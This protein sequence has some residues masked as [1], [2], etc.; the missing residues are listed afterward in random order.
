MKRTI[1]VMLICILSFCVISCAKKKNQTV[2]LQVFKV[3]DVQSIKQLNQVVY[4][5]QNIKNAS[6]YH[7]EAIFSFAQQIVSDLFT[8]NSNQVFSPLS[9]YIA[10]SMLTEGISDEGLGKKMENFL[11]LSVDQLRLFSKATFE[12]NYYS[13]DKGRTYLSNSMWIKHHF[14]INSEYID[15]LQKY[16]FVEAYR[17]D[18]TSVEAK[19]EIVRWINHYTEN[20]LDLNLD[21]YPI[22]D[23]LALLLLNTIYFNQKWKIA[24]S[25]E[26]NRSF[27]FYI[28][29]QSVLNH[30]FMEHKIETKYNITKDYTAIMD[31]FEN[32][33]QI[34]YVMPHQQS[35]SQEILDFQKIL[36]QMKGG[37]VQLAIPKFEFKKEYQLDNW[38]KSKGLENMYLKGYFEKIHKDIRVDYVKQ[39]VGIQ[40]SEEGVKAAVVTSIGMVPES[41]REVLSVRLDKPFYYVILDSFNTPLF[42]GYTFDPTQSE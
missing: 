18:F 12:N 13:N 25:K 26:E 24:F 23:E 29:E 3:K 35:F 5:Y 33:N 10:L 27:P 6:G 28:N 30:P 14:D 9:L 15:L 16:Y 40:F 20:L 36:N 41:T 34:L 1:Q 8:D 7:Q 42:I 4:P 17:V 32:G 2:P 31:D 39:N 38:L 19:K 37:T 11:G 22:S 21:N